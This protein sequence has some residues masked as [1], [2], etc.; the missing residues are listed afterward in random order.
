MEYK[1][2]ANT[3]Y[4]GGNI[5]FNSKTTLAGNVTFNKVKG[6]ITGP[7]FVDSTWTDKKLGY[8][9]DGKDNNQTTNPAEQVLLYN[10]AYMNI[11]PELSDLEYDIFDL[12]ISMGYKLKDNL[13]LGLSYLFSMVNDKKG[14]VYGDQDGKLHTVSVSIT[15]N[16]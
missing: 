5:I 9:Y 16:F 11:L 15:Y 8:L 4:A 7:N 14:Y 6:Y 2:N 3:V 10:Y 12:S 1:N 13:N